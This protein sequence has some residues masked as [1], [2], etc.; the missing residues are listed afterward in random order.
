[1]PPFLILFLFW[2]KR[3]EAIIFIFIPFVLLMGFF[4]LPQFVESSN[5]NLLPGVKEKQSENVDFSFYGHLYPDP[6]TYHFD[7]EVFL[8]E[9][10]EDYNQGE[11]SVQ[12]IGKSKAMKNV[13]VRKVSFWERLK[14]SLTIGARHVFRFFSLEYTGGPFVFLLMIFGF[15]CLRKR[16]QELSQFFIG[17]ISFSILMMSLVLLLIRNHLMDFNWAIA[18]TIALGILVFSQMILKY[19]NFKENK[20]VW[21]QLFIL[22]LLL[23]N[24]ILANHV[25]LGRVY[26]QTKVLEVRAYAE[27]INSINIQDKEVIA[28]DVHGSSLY[29]LNY[30]TNKSLVIFREKTINKLIQEDKLNQAFEKFNVKYILGYSEDLSNKILEN[31]EVE[32]IVSTPIDFDKEELSRNR[33]WLMNLIR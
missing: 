18:L 32:N 10:L 20:L 9:T 22:F 4:W 3:K 7:R 6:Y 12:K 27:E 23:Y 26:D 24:F 28:L 11:L 21:L 14:V 19:F 15:F 31:S 5:F 17:W 33:G 30:L 1:M 2:K 25:V 8:Q 29:Q 13:G 16:N